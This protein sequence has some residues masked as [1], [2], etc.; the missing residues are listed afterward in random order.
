MQFG[1]SAWQQTPRL[2]LGMGGI[3]IIDAGAA[4]ALEFAADRAR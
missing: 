3:G 1:Q 4:G 2:A